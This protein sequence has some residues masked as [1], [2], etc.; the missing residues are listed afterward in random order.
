MD[1]LDFVVLGLAQ[2]WKRDEEGQLTPLQLIEP[3][4]SAAFLALLQDIPSSFS[5][6]TAI[7]PKTMTEG[8]RPQAFPQEAILP[9]DFQERLE[10][11][12]RTFNH[13][14]NARTHL[15]IGQTKTIDKPLKQKRIINQTNIVSD[16]DNVKQHPNTSKIF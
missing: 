11:A 6:L 5:M 16:N 12:A 4:P 13:D 3:V 2:C 8:Q 9:A 1:S 7:D 15:P 14:K 10:A